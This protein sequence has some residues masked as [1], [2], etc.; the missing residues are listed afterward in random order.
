MVIYATDTDV[1]VIAIAVS[2]LMGSCEVWLAFGH[3]N[4]FRHIAAHTIANHIGHERAWGFCS[5]MQCLGVTPCQPYL[6]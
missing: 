1:V 5:F 4:K 2:S 3:G 6:G